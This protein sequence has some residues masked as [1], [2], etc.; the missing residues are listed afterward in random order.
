M[1]RRE[2]QQW[3]FKNHQTKSGIAKFFSGRNIYEW[4]GFHWSQWVLFCFVL[5]FSFQES[6]E[7]LG[8][9]C[10]YLCWLIIEDTSCKNSVFFWFLPSLFSCRS[11]SHWTSSPWAAQEMGWSPTVLGKCFRDTD[12]WRTVEASW[13]HQWPTFAETSSLAFPPCYTR[14]AW[15]GVT[16]AAPALC[17]SRTTSTLGLSRYFGGCVPCRSELGSWHKGNHVSTTVDLYFFE[18]ILVE[19]PLGLSGSQPS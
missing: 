19:F 12:V 5:F 6:K 4:E 2:L 18:S 13:R 9:L 16:T 11:V 17:F 7:H 1:P 15:V 14:Q 3:H 10:V 8:M